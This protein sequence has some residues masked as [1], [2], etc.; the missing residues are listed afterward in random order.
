MDEH[1]KIH[2]N[3]TE[4]ERFARA[5][6]KKRVDSLSDE[7]L[8]QFSEQATKYVDPKTQ[9]VKLR[10]KLCRKREFRM[11]SSFERHL[12]EHKSGRIR[13]VPQP[14]QQQ[15]Q[16]QPETTS[17]VMI[18]CED[19]DKSFNSSKKLV[20]HRMTHH[21]TKTDEH[22]C[23]RCEQSFDNRT[24][25]QAH[26]R[27]C[28][29]SALQ[30]SPSKG[31]EKRK[32]TLK[33][34]EQMMRQLKAD[35][36]SDD[37]EYE[38][39]EEDLVEDEA[40][41]VVATTSGD[42]AQEEM[43]TQ[44]VSASQSSANGGGEGEPLVAMQHDHATHHIREDNN[45]ETEVAELK[46]K[47][48]ST[49]SEQQQQQQQYVDNQITGGQQQEEVHHQ[50]NYHTFRVVTT[51][52]AGNT[53]GSPHH[54]QQQTGNND[55]GEDTGAVIQLRVTT[56]HGT[57]ED[58]ANNITITDQLLHQ[59][60]G[61]SGH[62][63]HVVEADEIVVSNLQ[64]MMNDP[65]SNA[66]AL[67]YVM[68][69]VNQA[70]GTNNEQILITTTTSHEDGDT[71]MPSEEEMLRPSNQD[72]ESE[73]ANTPSEMVVQSS[74]ATSN[75]ESEQVLTTSVTTEETILEHNHQQKMEIDDD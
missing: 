29:A 28:S 8:N 67:S 61:I 6:K 60:E 70:V 18:D 1:L 49:P 7:A 11:I 62:Q 39:Y 48:I 15:Q 20:R 33:A 69:C 56:S 23:S 64:E 16:Q 12:Q 21:Q 65:E 73:I 30:G 26:M 53:G 47:V 41:M 4:E 17:D 46:F 68:Q 40:H 54:L 57:D 22:D 32:A 34:K 14:Q 36:E 10:C 50:Q 13:T 59:E 2:L 58:V 71:V 45:A 25:L 51:T 27:K 75:V 42:G 24:I 74:I 55:T 19:C 9:E 63:H 31:S 35:E 5:A 72:V 3:E 52:T 38:E 43:V 44:T 37:D 66:A